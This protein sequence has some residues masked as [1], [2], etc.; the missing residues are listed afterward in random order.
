MTHHLSNTTST[1]SAL[2]CIHNITMPVPA[3]LHP[4][5]KSYLQSRLDEAADSL[6]GCTL[7]VVNTQG[8]LFSGATGPFDILDPSRKLST[9]DVMWFAS[10]TK[11]LTAICGLALCLL[12]TGYLQLV[13]RGALA[14]D[15]DMRLKFSPLDTAASRII[16]GFENGK[17]QFEDYRGPVPLLSLLNQSSGLNEESKELKEWREAEGASISDKVVGSPQSTLT[18]GK[19]SPHSSVLYAWQFVG[20]R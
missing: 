15:T 11:L 6:P 9:H 20:L 3:K 8:V 12:T 10:T 2:S 13:D 14:L 18:I 7:A 16:K 5:G 4:D 17:P 19:R 1:S